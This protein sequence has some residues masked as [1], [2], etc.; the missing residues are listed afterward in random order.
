VRL[1]SILAA[2]AVPLAAIGVALL[3]NWPPFPAYLLGASLVTFVLYGFDKRQARRGGG[4][5]PEAVLLA[6]GVA[7]GF[8]GGFLGMGIFRHKTRKLQFYAANM[9]G[10]LVVTPIVLMLPA[11]LWGL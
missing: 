8:L 7:G 1:Y 4:R 11:L 3:L 5:V 2:I 6:L 10:L 9:A